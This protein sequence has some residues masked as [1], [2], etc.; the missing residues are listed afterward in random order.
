MCLLNICLSAKS[1]MTNGWNVLQLILMSKYDTFVMSMLNYVYACIVNV[2]LAYSELRKT[3]NLEFWQV[4]LVKLA[5]TDS[6]LIH[7][8]L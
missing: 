2:K 4:T 1:V 6:P 5:S 3:V 7:V 8:Y